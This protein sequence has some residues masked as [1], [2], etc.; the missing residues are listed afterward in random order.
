MG[1]HLNAENIALVPGTNLDVSINNV[2]IQTN[3]AYYVDN[4]P[5][6]QPQQG[7]FPCTQDLSQPG[8]AEAD[9][10]YDGWTTVLTAEANVQICETYHIRLVVGDVGDGIFDSAVFLE[11]NSFSAGGD[12]SMDFDIAGVE[13]NGVAYEGC[14][15]GYIVFERPDDAN[16]NEDLVVEFSIDPGSTAT[17]G[18][19][20]SSL[21]PSITIPAGQTQFILPFDI[22]VDNLD[23]GIEILIL[24]LSNPCTCEE[25]SIDLQISDMLPLEVFTPDLEFCEQT[26]TQIPA[27]VTGGVPNYS[28]LWDNG[29]TSPTITVTAPVG[30]TTYTVTVTDECGNT[31]ESTTTIVVAEQEFAMIEGF[32]EVCVDDPTGTL[33]ITFDGEGPWDIVLLLDGVPVDAFVG[34]TEN[35]FSYDVSQIGTYT[36]GSLMVGPCPGIGTGAGLVIETIMLLFPVPEDVSCYGLFDGSVDLTVAGGTPEYTYAWSNDTY[37]EDPENLGPGL[38]TVT[39]TDLN[40]CTQEASVEIFDAEEI[41]AEAV[42][43]QPVD[44]QDPNSGAADLT[45]E[46]GNPG[47]TFEWDNG[48]EEEDPTNLSAGPHTVTVTDANGC[49]QEATVDISVESTPPVAA[50]E[51]SGML[52]CEVLDVVIDGSNSNGNNITFEWYNENDSLI[53]IEQQIE[54]NDTGAY[55]LV[56]TN[57]DNGCTADTTVVV[58]EDVQSPISDAGAS[59][60]LNCDDTVV[61]LDGSGSSSGQDFTYSWQDDSNTE[62]GDEISIEVGAPGTIYPYRYK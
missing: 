51:V 56:V 20:F 61:T 32:E 7:P 33:T 26:T 30:T 8:A 54:V 40:G 18:V 62:I 43:T 12:A 6:G 47:Y 10:E 27:N 28:Y 25:A 13:T 36:I 35:P 2:N 4:V 23:E 37:E 16:L 31:E 52:T 58:Q 57:T 34:I 22:F 41:L 24:N 39:V 49:T 46:G 42:E 15:G 3:S 14:S 19:D 21:P 5:I 48:S 11:A 9:C 44:C 55:T 60:T 53:S 17:N 50:A 29:M 38:Y 1:F 59:S 45:V